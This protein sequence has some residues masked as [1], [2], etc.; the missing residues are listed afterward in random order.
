MDNEA[1]KPKYIVAMS[2]S[3]K[4]ELAL[5]FALTHSPPQ[6][7]VIYIFHVFEDATK[8]FRRLDKLNAE[9]MERMRQIMV[10]TID[11]LAGRGITANVEDVERRFANG[12]VGIE[13][14]KMA[15]G[16]QP[17][18]LIMGAPSSNAFKKLLTHAPCT[19]VLVKDKET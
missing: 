8:N 4:S 10:G 15:E 3:R 5:E 16:V 18:L 6:G 12:K 14:F 9:T 19:L 11:R 17:D 7:A 2:F 13:L 1:P